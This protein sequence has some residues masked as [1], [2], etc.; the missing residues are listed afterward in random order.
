MYG[1]KSYCLSLCGIIIIFGLIEEK[2]KIDETHGT[3]DANSINEFHQKSFTI[4]G[5]IEKSITN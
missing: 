4:L 5:F 1:M 2:T 3:V